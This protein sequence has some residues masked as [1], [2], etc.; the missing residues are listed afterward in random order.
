MIEL[1][2]KVLD[3]LLQIY[4]YKKDKK[5]SFFE[6]FIQPLQDSFE[7]LH[8]DYLESFNSYR[9]KTLSDF[10]SEFILELAN[11]IRKD[12]FLTKGVRGKVKLMS[13]HLT[14]TEEKSRTVVLS[15][16]DLGYSV[17]NSLPSKSEK[18]YLE[19]L[20]RQ[21]STNTIRYFIIP[22]QHFFNNGGARL[23]DNAPRTSLLKGL[24]FVNEM[25]KEDLSKIRKIFKDNRNKN[26]L[27]IDDRPLIVNKEDKSEMADI[28]HFSGEYKIAAWFPEFIFD[29]TRQNVL[30]TNDIT[31]IKQA[32]TVA[33]IDNIINLLQSRYEMATEVYLLLKKEI[34]S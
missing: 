2:D 24:E 22:E 23:I 6:E 13:K 25:S 27:L 1:I 4:K 28:I 7:Q 5:K 10:S 33:L 20:L 15:S 17:I 34:K 21:Y 18:N 11:D 3:R 32:L 9:D 12:H 8:K 26:Y 31:K 30:K 16:D 19:K 29:K 14:D